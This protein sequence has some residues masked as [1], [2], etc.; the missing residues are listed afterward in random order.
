MNIKDVMGS[1][2]LESL[3]LPPHNKKALGLNPSWIF[4]AEFAYAS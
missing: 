4:C 2:A 1:L 3:A